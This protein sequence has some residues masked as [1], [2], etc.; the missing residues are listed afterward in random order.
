MIDLGPE[1]AL[2]VFV[3]DLDA[4]FDESVENA[5]PPVFEVALFDHFFEAR[6]KDSDEALV[7]PDDADVLAIGFL[8]GE[9]VAGLQDPTPL[10]AEAEVG[11]LDPGAVREH[12]C[13]PGLCECGIENC[14]FVVEVGVHQDRVVVQQIL[15]EPK[16]RDAIGNGVVGIVEEVHA[17]L[18]FPANELAF[19]AGDDADVGD[20]PLFEHRD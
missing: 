7:D 8:I 2:D 10:H 1:R 5:L 3:A 19:V 4:V 12:H 9:L 14:R 15:R 17:A 13:V 6:A 20:V 16:R 18:Q 11:V